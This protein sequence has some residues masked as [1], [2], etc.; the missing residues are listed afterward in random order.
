MLVYTDVI[1]TMRRKL[2]K[3]GP[4]TITVSLPS[5]WVHA[6]KLKPGNEV[7]VNL[8][9]N[10]L[11]I[12]AE[13]NGK[14]HATISIDVRD[15]TAIIPNILGALHKK[16]YDEIQ[17]RYSKEQFPAIQKEIT[18]HL[19]GYE[20]VQQTPDLLT[21][22]FVTKIDADELPILI[23]RVFLVTLSLAEGAV[24]AGD[25]K[26]LLV[27]EET[28]NRL[29]NYSE[30]IIIKNLYH[31]RDGL[32]QY[33]IVWLLEKIADDY[34]DIIRAGVYDKHDAQ[35]CHELFKEYYELF[36]KYSHKRFDE[37]VR[38]LIDAIAAFRKKDSKYLPVLLSLNHTRA[39]TIALHAE[40]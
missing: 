4:S 34:R 15:F 26:D 19:L 33:L 23:R 13:A 29:T 36:Y 11:V 30:R 37:F 2:V 28:N 12:S 7:T 8:E 9:H 21:I 3:Q 10:S 32:F 25:V 38:K 31:H 18:Q 17:L 24:Q 5:Q 27:L 20:I 39:S 1:M 22:R 6:N 16:G 35:V 14:D 40:Q